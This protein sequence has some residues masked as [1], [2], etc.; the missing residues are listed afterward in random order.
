[1]KKELIVEL[2]KQNKEFSR[3]GYDGHN[4]HPQGVT[5]GQLGERR[6]RRRLNA[7]L[8]ITVL[9]WDASPSVRTD[10]QNRKEIEYYQNAEKSRSA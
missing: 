1:M 6:R 3:I 8:K 5:M 10:W 7:N 9:Y 2:R 4:R